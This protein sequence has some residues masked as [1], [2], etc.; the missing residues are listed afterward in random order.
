MRKQLIADS[1]LATITMFWGFAFGLTKF[2]LLHVNSFALTGIRFLIGFIITYLI[3]WK[4]MQNIDYEVIKYSTILGCLLFGA[5]FSM[6]IGVKYT[7]ASNAGFLTNITVILV[8][9]IS[10]T[11]FKEKIF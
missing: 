6:T 1:A 2:A 4:R 9:I 8:P 3:F 7:S 10:I 5:V 11:M